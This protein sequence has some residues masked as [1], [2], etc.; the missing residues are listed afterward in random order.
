MHSA[1]G[2]VDTTAAEAGR[3]GKENQASTLGS[4]LGVPRSTLREP[5]EVF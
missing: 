5:W 4:T 1:Q 2:F 3:F